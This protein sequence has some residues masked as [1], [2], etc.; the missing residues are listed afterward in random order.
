VA[1]GFAAGAV[2]EQGM[3]VVGGILGK[4]GSAAAENAIAKG[5][6]SNAADAAASSGTQKVLEPSKQSKNCA[7]DANKG[8]C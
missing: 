1:V 4:A 5:V 7:K 8:Q 6:V 3:G 2:A